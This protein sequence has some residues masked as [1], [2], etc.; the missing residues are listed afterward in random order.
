ML[1][2]AI[3][4]CLNVALGLI[5]GS[6]ILMAGEYKI[7]TVKVL[8]IE[9]YPAQEE[10]LGLTVAVDPYSTNAKSFTAFDVK[11]LNSEGYFPLHVIIKNSTSKF[12]SLKTQN[13]VLATKSGQQLY[14]TPATLIVDDVIRSGLAPKPSN[15][16]NTGSPLIDFTSKELTS[17]TIDPETT[18]D[19]FLFFFTTTPRV[20]PFVGATL[21]IPKFE[22]EGTKKTLGPFY[23][24]L[25]STAAT[26]K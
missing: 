3:M 5:L 11:H 1:L 21:F 24:P 16:R 10:V 22:E 13:I 12:Y 9:S 14:T 26:Q 15:K 25:D 20:N 17:R 6:A 4:R 18:S 7:K 23:I 19:G 8:P 2:L